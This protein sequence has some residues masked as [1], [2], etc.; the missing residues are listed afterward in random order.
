MAGRYDF[1]HMSDEQNMQELSPFHM[2]PNRPGFEEYGHDNGFRYWWASDLAAL[3]GYGGLSGLRTAI[4]RAMTTLTHLNIAIA[5]N[6][7]ESS[8]DIA[9]KLSKDY[10]LSRFACYVVA[11]NGDP[12][13]EQVALAQGYFARW[14]EACALMIEDAEGMDRIRIR[15]DITNAER[16]LAGVA[17]D[18]KVENYAYFQNAGYRGMY[19]MNTDRIREIKGAPGRRSPL[20]FMGAAELAA[21]E[22]RI[23]QTEVRIKSQQ[24]KGQQGLES[25]A[26]L[27]GRNVRH[28]MIASGGELPEKM[29]P[30]KDLKLVKKQIKRT[31]KEL[32]ALDSPKKAASRKV[33]PARE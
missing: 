10:K 9:G 31:N 13:K 18:A 1:S 26:N 16:S 8:R 15:T 27:V 25:A 23:S 33:K 24:I 20:D 29:P 19:N 7:V 12:Q 32:K 21:N 5:E 2:E 17:K 6:M 22:F 28:A 3:L 11:M 4:N 30:A 14:A